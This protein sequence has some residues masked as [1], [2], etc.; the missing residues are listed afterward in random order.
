VLRAHEVLTGHE[1]RDWERAMDFE[2]VFT[3]TLIFVGLLTFAIIATAVVTCAR[4]AREGRRSLPNELPDVTARP[5]RVAPGPA[6]AALELVGS[7]AA[8]RN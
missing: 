5:R 8:S 7:G 2:I 6:R 4:I 3:G 1:R